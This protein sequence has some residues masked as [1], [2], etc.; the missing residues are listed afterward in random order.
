MTQ[1]VQS[2]SQKSKSAS[3]SFNALEGLGFVKRGGDLRFLTKEG[4]EFA[5]DPYQSINTLK[6]IKESLLNYGPF[7]GLLYEISGKNNINRS[8]VELGYPVTN[9]RIEIDGKFVTLSTGSQQDTITR[10]RSV[11]F[12]WA[13]TGG[14]VLPSG[15]NKPHHE[16]IWHLQTLDYI[17][18]KRW[19]KH[20]FDVLFPD[21]L[22]DTKRV[23]KQPLFYDAMTKSTK[24][25]RERNQDVQ[26]SLTLKFE[27][28]IKNRRFAIVYALSKMS[29]LNKSL[30]LTKFIK[31]LKE[32]PDLFVVDTSNFDIIIEKEL[33]IAKICGIPFE[34]KKTELFPQT[35]L[36]IDE[37]K[38]GSPS[39]LV[40]VLE[41]ISNK[42]R[43]E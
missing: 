26:R 39:S 22:F 14:F 7:I 12:I 32:Y 1:S 5:S 38:K 18:S 13:T 31:E 21:S 37:L 6:R 41:I 27:T 2:D 36:D 25:L 20:S 10:T 3:D 9:E 33:E 24:A 42:L 17:K 19:S 30:E 8:E 34:R 40:D 43:D 23:V 11:L 28:V 4:I 15:I 29:E 16:S 35:I